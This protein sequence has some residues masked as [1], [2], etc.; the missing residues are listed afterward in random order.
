VRTSTSGWGLPKNI[1]GE[2]MYKSREVVVIYKER[3]Y[4]SR[5][6]F[7]KLCIE[8]NVPDIKLSS[9]A[10]TTLVFGYEILYEVPSGK[11]E[12][13]AKYNLEEALWLFQKPIDSTQKFKIPLKDCIFFDGYTLLPLQK[14]NLKGK[15]HNVKPYLALVRVFGR[16]YVVC[17][18]R[19][20]N[21]T[22]LAVMTQK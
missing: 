12:K 18:V 14:L 20:D 19:K 9:V 11:V 4:V 15:Y 13:Y 16:F 2:N 21:N 5:E 3:Y 6:L 1:K 10:T 22:D 8:W 7:E 17:N